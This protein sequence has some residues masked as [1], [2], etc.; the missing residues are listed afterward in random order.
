MNIPSLCLNIFES[1]S[2]KNPSLF[3]SCSN[4]NPSLLF[5]KQV[6]L[7]AYI[8]NIFSVPNMMKQDQRSAAHPLVSVIQLVNQSASRSSCV[9]QGS[10]WV[11]LRSSWVTLGSS[12]VTLRSSWFILG[13][14]GVNWGHPGSH[15]VNQISQGQIPGYPRGIRL[16]ERQIERVGANICPSKPPTQLEL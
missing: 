9:T 14:P 2:N 11:N 4:K 8:S 15:G 13:H 5:F 3:E 16:S 7:V 6:P 1:C 12:W 10:S